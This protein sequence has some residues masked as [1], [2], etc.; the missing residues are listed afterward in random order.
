M[1]D[2]T[3]WA[4]GHAGGGVDD[5]T[6]PWRA[7]RVRRVSRPLRAWHAPRPWRL[8]R[9]LGAPDGP[10]GSSGPR[11]SHAPDGPG[12]SSR[13]RTTDAPCRALG[14]GA[15]GRSRG[16]CGSGWSS[17][18]GTNGRVD[19]IEPIDDLVDLF[20]EPDHELAESGDVFAGRYVHR[21]EIGP[22]VVAN[23]LLGGEH[24]LE[25]LPA[26]FVVLGATHRLLERR[27]PGAFVRVVELAPGLVRIRLW[28][29]VLGLWP[30]LLGRGH[31][32]VSFSSVDSS[33]WRWFV[34]SPAPYRPK[35][36]SIVSRYAPSIAADESSQ[37]RPVS[38]IV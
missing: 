26:R 8:L 32:G 24:R 7:W 5:I 36:R 27:G 22:H 15:P 17:R 3:A 11:A 16:S 38:V 18:H 2:Q 9:G 21:L 30:C 1:D 20:L 12:R 31:R 37:T 29:C 23:R 14:P 10:C 19:R 28:P 4:S 34:P 25:H 33:G 35:N 13:P 6:R